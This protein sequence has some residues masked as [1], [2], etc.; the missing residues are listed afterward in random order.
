M[1]NGYKLIKSTPE[2]L[3]RIMHIIADAQELLKTNNIDQWQNGYPNSPQIK[4]DIAQGDSFVVCNTKNQIVA[5]VF[6]TT[7]PEP[8]Y[9]KVYKGQWLTPLSETYGTIHRLAVG[10]NQRGKGIA[11]WVITE[12][13]QLLK[14][15]NI[16][17][18]K[19]DT[20]PDN[21][22]MQQLIGKLGYH[23]CGEIYL[24]DG[25]LRL[26]YEKNW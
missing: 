25:A 8:T 6:L 2:H 4:R 12:C 13:E 11:K 24:E 20:H 15:Q 21:K 1:N 23:Y 22:G 7:T 5:T 26:A 18:L 16:S 19:I 3:P 9:Q 14:Q 10:A 17:N